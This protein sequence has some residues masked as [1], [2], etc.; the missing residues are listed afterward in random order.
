MKKAIV[1]A[2]MIWT[3]MGASTAFSQVKMTR[4]QM[5]FYTSD[6]K[7]DRFPD[8]RPKVPDDLLKRA[9]DVSIEDIWDYL[10]EE[11]YRNQFE[12]D[13]QALHIEKPFAGRA[14]TAQYMPVRLTWRRRSLRKER[15]KEGSVET[16]AGRSMSCRSAMC[17]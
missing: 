11:G 3:A 7:G 6:W 8:G 2:V 13:W 10:R 15:P 1:A 5:M 9:L 17:M 14:L 4:D 16:I 12:G